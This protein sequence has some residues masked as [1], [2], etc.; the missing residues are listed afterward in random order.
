MDSVPTRQRICPASPQACAF[1][2]V[3]ILASGFTPARNGDRAL[4]LAPLRPLTQPPSLWPSILSPLQVPACVPAA[5]IPRLSY[6]NSFRLIPLPSKPA[7]MESSLRVVLPR[8]ELESVLT[9]IPRV[10][11]SP[12]KSHHTSLRWFCPLRPLL[13]PISPLPRRPPPS[14]NRFACL[15]FSSQ[16]RCGCHLFRGRRLWLGGR[17][18]VSLGSPSTLGVLGSSLTTPLCLTF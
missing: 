1:R 4:S 13:R 14:G 3:L 7:P 10:S 5:I 16:V 8:R 12:V 11:D 2:L 17:G 18:A 6:L 9:C 15:T